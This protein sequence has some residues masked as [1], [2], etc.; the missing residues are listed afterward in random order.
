MEPGGTKGRPIYA[1]IAVMVF[2]TRYFGGMRFG[3]GGLVRAY[4]GIAADCLK[5]ALTHIVK[6]KIQNNH[7]FWN[8]SRSSRW[9]HGRATRGCN[10]TME[11]ERSSKQFEQ[12]YE[13]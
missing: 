13:K 1:A 7:L 6:E 9:K 2:V 4:G 10:E 5:D 3:T 11:I 8:G 12:D